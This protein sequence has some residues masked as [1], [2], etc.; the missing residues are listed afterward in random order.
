MNGDEFFL[1]FFAFI[2]ASAHHVNERKY[3]KETLPFIQ[4][5]NVCKPSLT[6][7]QSVRALQ[8][9]TGHLST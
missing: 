2:N 6:D 7:S 4:L 3:K 8:S 9:C 1:Y 5:H